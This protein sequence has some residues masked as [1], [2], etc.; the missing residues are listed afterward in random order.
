MFKNIF[1]I[2][3]CADQEECHAYAPEHR[4][5]TRER[6][7]ASARKLFNRH[8]LT[9]VS[10][11]DVMAGAGLTRGGFYNYFDSK[12][13]LYAEAITVFA[14]TFP[15][16]S[17]QQCAIGNPLPSGAALARRIIDAYL[18]DEHF[19]SIEGSC[20]MIA[21][22]SDVARGGEATKRAFREVL[23]MMVGAFSAGAN[24]GTDGEASRQQQALA[25]ASLCVGGMVLARA[26][27]DATLADALRTAAKRTALVLA[28][29]DDAAIGATSS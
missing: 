1:S 24:E 9:G 28:G 25:L 10:I 29:L 3:V 2:H 12:E 7:I 16:E 21:L 20:P 18:S 13:E 17:W 11:D 19:A 6:I 8:G 22:P 4:G 26:V 15:A 23:Q 27:D 5:E 14:R